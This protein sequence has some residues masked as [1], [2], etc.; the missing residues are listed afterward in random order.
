MGEG[1]MTRCEQYFEKKEVAMP[2]LANGDLN[3]LPPQGADNC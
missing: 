1:Y 3:P 2:V